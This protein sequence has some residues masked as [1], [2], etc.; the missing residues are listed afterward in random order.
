MPNF[1]RA[2][3]ASVSEYLRFLETSR[4]FQLQDL[5]IRVEGSRGD[6]S[7][8]DG[9][10]ASLAPLWRWFVDVVVDGGFDDAPPHRLMS[11]SLFLSRPAH[12]QERIGVL[13]EPVAFY[14]MEA[15]RSNSADVRWGTDVSLAEGQAE[16]R[17]PGMVLDSRHFVAFD[18]VGPGSAAAAQR[19]VMS[20]R[21]AMR[22]IERLEL[23]GFDPTTANEH[24]TPL[25]TWLSTPRIEWDDPARTP[26]L[27]QRADRMDDGRR[28]SSDVGLMVAA[29]PRNPED[30]SDWD[31]LDPE[32]VSSE[33]N[34]LGWRLRSGRRISS[35][36]VLNPSANLLWGPAPGHVVLHPVV[37]AGHTRALAVTIV[38]VNDSEWAEV[39]T[40]LMRFAARLGGKLGTFEDWYPEGVPE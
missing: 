9:S 14:V 38:G 7:V 40:G 33:L 17:E 26:P 22:L 24:G 1:S 39:E 6:M 30:A 31:P 16:F 25:A 18:D 11:S 15:L 21:S 32:I 4:T 20:A 3:A 19:G 12:R 10:I 28:A 5:A 37:E 2:S 27:G 8:L 36:D 35:Q 23:A 29:R 34:A 13:A